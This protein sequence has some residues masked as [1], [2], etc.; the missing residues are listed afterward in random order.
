MKRRSI[1]VSAAL[2]FCSLFVLVSC[3]DED[4]GQ[5]KTTG[6]SQFI[7]DG[8]A[9]KYPDNAQ[10]DIQ[11]ENDWA[12]RR[13]RVRGPEVTLEGRVYESYAFTLEAFG[14]TQAGSAREFAETKLMQAYE[15]AVAA[16]EA[17][18][19]WPFDP[20][21]EAVD[22]RS[23]RIH[24]LEGWEIRFPAGDAEIVRRFVTGPEMAHAVALS[25]RADPAHPLAAQHYSM[26]IMALESLRVN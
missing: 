2:L 3:V 20:E 1:S 8:F 15:A 6:A 12:A 25:Y 16:N 21:T 5:P 11:R 19:A 24:G 23:V 22:G 10:L 26:Y 4:P 9:F 18:E 7:G 17:T 14:P 13:I